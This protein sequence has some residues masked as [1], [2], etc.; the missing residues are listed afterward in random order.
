[1]VEGVCGYENTEEMSSTTFRDYILLLGHHWREMMK[2]RS[3]RWAVVVDL[4]KVSFWG[5]ALPKSIMTYSARGILC[6][7]REHRD[8]YYKVMYM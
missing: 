3:A 4:P 5:G 1:M 8:M 7:D 2:P 6:N